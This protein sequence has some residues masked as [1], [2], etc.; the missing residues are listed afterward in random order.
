MATND[1]EDILEQRYR[2]PNREVAGVGVGAVEAKIAII[3]GTIVGGFL[4][5]ANQ[6]AI[7]Q[8]LEKTPMVNQWVVAHRDMVDWGLTRFAPKLTVHNA[9]VA[10]AVA[11]MFI[12]PTIAGFHGMYMGY[13]QA[14]RGMKQFKGAQDEIRD[15]RTQVVALKAENATWQKRIESERAELEAKNQ[16]AEIGA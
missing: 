7:D 2:G 6:A 11:G 12:L 16:S 1:Q 9:T 4:G 14:D 5:A 15:L 13:R 10:G 3:P 8:Y